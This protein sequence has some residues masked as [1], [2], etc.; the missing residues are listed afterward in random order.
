MQADQD[1]DVHRKHTAKKFNS[2]G[3][4]DR[5]PC[6]KSVFREI[7]KSLHTMLCSCYKEGP[8]WTPTPPFGAWASIFKKYRILNLK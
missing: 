1:S 4:S 7:L 3:N 5:A 6:S 2:K 8:Q